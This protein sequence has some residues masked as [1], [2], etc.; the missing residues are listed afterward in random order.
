MGGSLVRFSRKI[1]LCDSAALREVLLVPTSSCPV[2][3]TFDTGEEASRYIMVL[4][5]SVEMGYEIE[6][7]NASAS[8]EGKGMLNPY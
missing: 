1:R 8:G 7:R 5:R 6:K 4:T 2:P 3:P